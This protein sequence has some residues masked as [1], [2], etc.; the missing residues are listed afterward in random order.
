MVAEG[1]DGAG[2]Q[3]VLR[4][5]TE[6]S[7]GVQVV[8]RERL[9][10][11]AD[12]HQGIIAEAAPYQY[13]ELEDLLASVSGA[14]PER[15]PLLVAIDA[16]QDPQNFGALLRTAVA[17]GAS[18]AILPERRAVGVTPAVGR[19]SAGAIEYLKIA[20]VVNLPRALIAAKEV[21]LWV[22][23][24][25]GSGRESYDKVDLSVPLVVVV[26]AEGAG[27]GRLVAETCDI[28]AR[29]PMIGPIDSLNVAVAGS[30][31]LYEA[32]RQRRARLND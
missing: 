14:A 10:A 6:R 28:V 30:I 23:G 5:A 21:G 29:L 16:L 13:V 15:P 24:L 18:G 4:L 19:A 3:G 9:D 27:L 17:V 1:A 22:V 11:L 7:V 26:G 31:V 20:R 8:P 32:L 12:H 25:D 2:V